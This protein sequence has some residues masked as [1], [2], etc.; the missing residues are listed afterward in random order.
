[1][2]ENTPHNP[3]APGSNGP[4]PPPNALPA[5]EAPNARLIV[6]L[7]LVPGILVALVIGFILLFFGGVGGGPQT[8][9]EFL[10]GLNSPTGIQR[11]KTAQD[12]AQVLPRRPELRTDPKFALDM[13]DF[14]QSELK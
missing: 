9:D 3:P 10:S 12:L 14:L 6:Q 1:M 5:V 2:P 11:W 4:P 8:P 13:A 7:F